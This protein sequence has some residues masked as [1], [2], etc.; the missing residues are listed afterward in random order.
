MSTLEIRSTRKTGPGAWLVT[1]ADGLRYP[2]VGGFRDERDVREHCIDVR[3]DA[4]QTIRPGWYTIA[5]DHGDH[6]RTVADAGRFDTRD[7]A[8]LAAQ[9]L[10]DETGIEHA[11]FFGQAESYNDAARY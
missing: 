3:R 2:C 8:D 7:A 6:F 4:Q 9:K 1:F 11:S 10:T 5:R